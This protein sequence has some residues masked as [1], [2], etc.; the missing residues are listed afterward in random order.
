MRSPKPSLKSRPSKTPIKRRRCLIPGGRLIELATREGP[1]GLH[2]SIAAWRPMGLASSPKPGSAPT[3]R[4]SDIVA[5]VHVGRER[6]IGLNLHTAAGDDSAPRKKFFD[7]WL[8]LQRPDEAET[9]MALLTARRRASSPGTRWSIRV[10]TSPMMMRTDSADHG[11]ADGS[12]SAKPNE[13][14]VRA[15]TAADDDGPGSV[16]LYR[17]M[18]SSSSR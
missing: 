7:R 3:A 12:R 5:I 6:P 2:S 10:N 4:N 18:L 8:R 15:R 16:V 1:N 14:R 9:V 11:G 17:D 13:G